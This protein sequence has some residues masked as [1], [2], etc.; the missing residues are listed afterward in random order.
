MSH[1][2]PATVSA[3]RVLRDTPFFADLAPPQLE[4]VA[5]LGTLQ[6]RAE[7]EV[8]Y[9]TGEPARDMYVLV[10]GLVRMAVGYHGRSASGGD[11]L[12]RG[13]V[14]GWAA[15]TPTCNL[16][17][18]TASCLAPCVLLVLDGEHLLALMEQDHTIG[19]R[20]TTQLT[21]LITGTLSALAGG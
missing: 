21:R 20:L 3:D 9:R 2:T 5:A 4:R 13:D 15:L 1:D 19:Y 7:G 18:A 14:F 12:R 11:V 10:Q 16:R 8:L 6:Q 17:V